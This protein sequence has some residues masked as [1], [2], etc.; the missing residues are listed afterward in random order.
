MQ[1]EHPHPPER[2]LLLMC[3]LALLAGIV[4]GVGAWVFRML[5]GVVHNTLF[6]GNPVFVYD[7]NVH[8]PAGPW[9]MWVIAVPVFGGLV[10]AWLVKTFAPEAR[11]HGVPE[12][13]DAI[14]YQEGRI[15]PRVAIIKSV[16]SAISIGSGAF[17][18]SDSSVE[19]CRW[20]MMT[21]M[22][23]ATDSIPLNALRG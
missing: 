5:I 14:Y 6:L 1:Q 7:A 2:N 16:A 19:R 13:M 23:T 12:V 21:S 11:G 3:L 4:G 18:N 15:R 20:S 8:T 10:V 9:G 22:R 17:A